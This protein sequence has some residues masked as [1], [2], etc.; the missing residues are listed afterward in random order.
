MCVHG[1]WAFEFHVLSRQRGQSGIRKGPLPR[2][3][4]LSPELSVWPKPALALLALLQA[5]VVSSVHF[6]RNCLCPPNPKTLR[7]K[8]SYLI[9]LQVVLH[10]H[11]SYFYD[12]VSQA[13]DL[14][15]I[16]CQEISL[17]VDLCYLF[18][19]HELLALRLL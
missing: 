14:T 18:V 10:F 12:I 13:K 9:I 1:F 11:C 3:G 4:S 19:K 2:P 15:R 5:S 8:S 7:F 16:L 6:Q 17:L